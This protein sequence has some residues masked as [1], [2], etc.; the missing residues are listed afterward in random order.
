MN[1]TLL[2]PYG[3][4]Y[5]VFS[6]ITNAKTLL[7]VTLN[8]GASWT[9]V[10]CSEKNF[11]VCETTTGKLSQLPLSTHYCYVWGLSHCSRY[12]RKYILIMHQVAGVGV[13]SSEAVQSADAVR[14]LDIACP[15]RMVSLY[16]KARCLYLEPSIFT[17]SSFALPPFQRLAQIIHTKF[18][19]IWLAENYFTLSRGYSS[20]NFSVVLFVERHRIKRRE[21]MQNRINRN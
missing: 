10:A 12:Y 19:W 1:L 2:S 9:T 7:Y 3:F 11:L 6:Q 18:I 20:P 17:W 5:A 8:S 16:I 4:Y 21:K 15:N 13:F 14:N